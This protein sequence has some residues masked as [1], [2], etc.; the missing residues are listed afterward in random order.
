[1]AVEGDSYTTQ[2]HVEQWVQRGT[3]GAGSKPTAAQV[4]EAMKLRASE[5]TN[6][7]IRSGLTAS[8]PTGGAPLATTTD[9]QKALKDCCDLANALLAAG[10]TIFMHDTRDQA[11]VARAQ[12]LWAEGELKLDSV[13][14]LAQV[15]Q[16]G[17]VDE[18]GVRNAQTGGIPHEDFTDSGTKTEVDNSDLFNMGTRF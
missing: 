18:I 2:A 10:D 14:M 8:P 12:A 6:V 7:L 16:L 1:M 11:T 5:I 15:A 4:L 13:E 3:F 9:K 17:S